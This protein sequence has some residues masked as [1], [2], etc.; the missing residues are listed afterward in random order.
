[1]LVTSK[2]NSSFSEISSKNRDENGYIDISGIN[3]KFD[4]E[5]R[6]KIGMVDREKNWIRFNDGRVFLLKEEISYGAERTASVYSELIVEELAK[7]AGLEC[8]HYDLYKKDEKFGVLSEYCLK[9]GEEMFSLESLIG[10]GALCEF[11]SEKTDAIRLQ[12]NMIE[13]LKN[14]GLEKNEIKKLIVDFQKRMVFDLFMLHSDRHTENISFRTRCDNEGNVS[15]DLAPVYDNENC[16]LLD[17]DETTLNMLSQ[18]IRAIKK[19]TSMIAPKIAI[20]EDSFSSNEQI[21]QET[22]DEYCGVDQVYDYLMD[23]YDVLDIDDAFKKVEE[24]IRAPIPQTIKEVA[25]YAFEYRKREIDKVMCLQ[26][27]GLT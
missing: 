17:M 12:E 15:I 23:L 5:S 6:E 16:L 19:S 18:D 20:V 10:Q 8:A 24:R 11:D 4:P 27:E 26:Y 14:E 2:A 7:Q 3:F 25:K 9:E 13:F 1:M 21:W 22:L